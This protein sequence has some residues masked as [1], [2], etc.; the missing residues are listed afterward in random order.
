MAAPRPSKGHKQIKHTTVE[1]VNLPYPAL[2]NDPFFN[3]GG[4]QGAVKPPLNDASGA[5]TSPRNKIES[6]GKEKKRIFAK[7]PS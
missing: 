4:F 5:A 6:G 7:G 3:V 1:Y 2:W